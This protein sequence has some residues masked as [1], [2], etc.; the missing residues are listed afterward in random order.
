M[1]R[2]VAEA[3][4]EV[5][6]QKAFLPSGHV[7]TEDEVER[8]GRFTSPGAVRVEKKLPEKLKGFH[9]ELVLGLRTMRKG[10]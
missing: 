1:K 3:V 7:A 8:A 4:G 10:R 5:L 2:D 6:K 9:D